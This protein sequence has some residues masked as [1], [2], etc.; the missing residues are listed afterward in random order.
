M[1]QDTIVPK[2]IFPEKNKHVYEAI[3]YVN[4]HFPDNPGNAFDFNYPVTFQSAI[5][6]LDDFLVNRLANF[7]VYQDAIVSN[8]VFLFHSVLTP[9]LNTGILSPEYT[10]NRA[11]DFHA[12]YDYPIISL[13]GFVRQVLGWREYIRAI[14]IQEGNRQ[15]TSNYW[16]AQLEIPESFWNASTGI[17][18]ID[19]VIRKVLKYGW[20]H[21]IERIMVLG[22]FM[23]LCGFHPNKV[24]DWFMSLF[25][26]AYE[27][28]M[29][30][31][32]YGMSQY[33]DGGL[34]SIKPYITSSN[35]ILKMINYSKGDWC[36][37]WDALYYRF[38]LIHRDELAQ[39]PRMK[40]TVHKIDTMDKDKLD[41]Y[42]NKAEDFLKS[43]SNIS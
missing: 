33:A 26:D 4:N 30:P 28:V 1:P 43:L 23:Q 17:E 16:N 38:I 41:I 25:I 20:C 3:E 32:V 15:R 13:E 24:Y 5:Q 42:I 21:H 11:V 31:N 10:I 29:V 22:N 36:D 9:V 2:I 6:F 35:Y 40:L 8:E 39:N 18:P 12:D 19:D 34:M 14:Y 37:I 27:W 7:G